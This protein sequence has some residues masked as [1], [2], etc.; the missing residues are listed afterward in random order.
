[1]YQ[2]NRQDLRLAVNLWKMAVRDRY[3]GSSLG[4]FWAVANPLFMLALYTFVFGFVFKVRLPGAESTLEYVIWL[5]VGYGPWIATTEAIMAAMVV[6]NIPIHRPV[7]CMA[8]LCKA[9]ITA[10]SDS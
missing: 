6:R 9:P 10:T 3:L 7:A 4:S 8:A 5:I 2:F 1:M